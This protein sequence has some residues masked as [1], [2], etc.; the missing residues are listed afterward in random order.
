MSGLA[1][2]EECI[3][4]NCAEGHIRIWMRPQD[5]ISSSQVDLSKDGVDS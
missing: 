5:T 2:E 3:I 4:T 1:F